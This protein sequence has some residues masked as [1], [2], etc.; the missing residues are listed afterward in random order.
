MSRVDEMI[1]KGIQAAADFRRFDQEKT[2]RIVRSVFLAAFEQRVRLARMAHEE[3]GIGIWTHKVIK[4]VIATQLVYNN[5]KGVKTVGV[6]SQDFRLGVVEIAQ[7]VGLILALVPVTNPTATVF[8]KSLIAM[9][10]RNPII[11]SPHNAARRCTAEAVRV[12][13]EAALSAGAPEH[14][15]QWLTKSTPRTT[16]ELMKHRGLSLIIATGTG[17][18]VR[19]AYSSG[20]P[21]I[22]VGPGNVPVYIGATADIPFA[23]SSILESKTFDNGSVCASEQAIVVKKEASKR[24]IDE[25]KTQ[26]AYFMTPDEIE[27]VG[28]IAYDPERSTMTPTVVGQS[29]QRIARSAG[30]DVPADT[31]VLIGQLDGVG[32]DYPLSAEILAPILAFYIEDDFDPAIERCSE[33]TQYGG[34]GHTAV[35]YSN[36][37][38]RIEYFSRVIDAGRILVNMPSTQGA[39]GGIFNSLDPS[40][41]LACGSRGNNT[42]T[43]NI[44]ARHLLNIHRITRRRPNP[45]WSHFDRSRFLDD[46]FPPE[47][48]EREY[49]KNF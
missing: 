17:G 29:T 15:I 21:V 23:V 13:Y 8:F 45:R 19:E 49:N 37:D 48:L 42:S 35:I 7:P 22:G 25:F 20:T 40:F 36:N 9:K 47:T 46:S 1:E 30:F 44:T 11:I 2:D 12:C 39:L 4:N 6:I 28:K 26:K 10:S 18:L 43:D 16:S 14:C 5:I 33:I 38:E 41:T 34:A 31:S 32:R 24:V 3:T 27:S